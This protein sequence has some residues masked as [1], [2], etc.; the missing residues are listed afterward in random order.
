M[1]FTFTRTYNDDNMQEIYSKQQNSGGSVSRKRINYCENVYEST[2][3]SGI[4]D[5]WLKIRVFWLWQTE[6]VSVYHDSSESVLRIDYLLVLNLMSQLLR[7]DQ[8]WI[9]NQP[10][11]LSYLSSLFIVVLI[12]CGFTHC[13][14]NHDIYCLSER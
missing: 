5:W 11:L 3:L 2:S 14:L 4:S 13:P 7:S 9:Q 6:S 10:T 1:N 8:L 12:S